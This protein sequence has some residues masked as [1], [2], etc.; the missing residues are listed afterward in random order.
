MSLMDLSKEQKQYLVLGVIAAIALGVLIVFGIK[1]SLSSISE[2]RLELQGFTEKV[3]SAEKSVSQ[4]QR[5]EKEFRSTISELKVHLA[6]MPPDRNYYSWATEIIYDEARMVHFEI[7]AID[8]MGVAA[9]ANNSDATRAVELESYSLRI[10]AHGGY[11]SIKQFFKRIAINHPLV[12]ITGL[13]ISTGSTPDIHD[14]QLF[15]EWPFNLGYITE[16]WKDAPVQPS[17]TDPPSTSPVEPAATSDSVES[18]PKKEPLPPP[19]RSVQAAPTFPEGSMESDIPVTG[20]TTGTAGTS[21][22]QPEML[23]EQ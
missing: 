8:E 7:D 16:A 23:L 10:T 3:A 21:D 2:A 9:A 18:G 20:V 19:A 13:D 11:E 14:V 5:N 12:R 4:N 17:L 22:N 15:I 6:N 1:V